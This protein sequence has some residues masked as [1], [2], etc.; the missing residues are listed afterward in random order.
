[1]KNIIKLFS[2][3]ALVFV[4]GCTDPEDIIT[5][6]AQEGVF[7]N[8]EGSGTLAGAPEPGIDLADATI[9]FQATQL[10]YNVSIPFGEERVSELVAY[11][12]FNGT[13]IE[14]GRA[15]GSAG[16][17]IKLTTLSEFLSGFSGLSA[18]DLRVGDQIAFYTEIHMTDGRVLIDNSANL[19]V[20]ISC[21]AD[22]T[23]T[24]LVT[25]SWC[26]PLFTVII[27]QN[28][29]GSYHLTSADGGGLSKCTTNSSLANAGDI[30]EQCGE[31]LPSTA[32]DFGTDGGYGIGDITGGTWDAQNGVITMNHVQGFTGNWPSE[33][34]STYTRQ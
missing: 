9:S 24:Y 13:T 26:S 1:M 33:W 2:L 11:K 19:T 18:D 8:L 6:D 12:S 10:D 4:A 5:G 27:T 32:L 20:S 22:L 3:A 14:L 7:L 34:T 15:S 31:I 28:P 16:L 17:S 21:L 25:N 29:D 30:V 23:G